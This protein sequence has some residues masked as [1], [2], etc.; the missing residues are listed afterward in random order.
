MQD[1][2]LL[3]WPCPEWFHIPISTEWQDIKQM[4]GSLWLDASLPNTYITN[5]KLQY[6]WYIDIY[7][8][9]EVID[10]TNRNIY[11]CANQYDWSAQYA[12]AF[13]LWNR[14][15]SDPKTA[16]VTNIWK[17]YWCSIRPFK[18][19]PVIPDNTWTVLYDW[20]SIAA[21]AWTFRNQWLWLVSIS[22]DWFN[23][24]TIS[25]TDLS[26]NQWSYYQRW[27]NFW[28]PSY[29]DGDDTVNSADTTW[30]WPWNYYSSWVLIRPW[31][32][33]R[34]A[35]DSPINP[36][37]WWYESFI[38]GQNDIFLWEWPYDYSAM[39]WQCQEWYHI[40]ESSELRDFYNKV[41]TFWLTLEDVWFPT[42][43]FLQDNNWNLNI[44]FAGAE[45]RSCNSER[46]PEW[47]EY[48]EYLA[49]AL[50][51]TW[52][53]YKWKWYWCYIRP[54]R[55]EPIIPDNSWTIIYDGS[56]TASWAWIFHNPSLG[57][58]SY[59]SDWTTWK[60]IA[61]KNLW[62]ENVYVNWDWYSQINCWWFFQ[63]WNCYMFPYTWAVDK[64]STLVAVSWY[65][66]WNYYSSSTFVKA[67]SGWQSRDRASDTGVG[68]EDLWWWKTWRIWNYDH[69]ELY[70]WN[71]ISKSLMRWPCQE[72]WH[73]PSSI[74]RSW[75][76]TIME[77]IFAEDEYYSHINT[78][79]YSQYLHLPISWCLHNWERVFINEQHWF[80]WCSTPDVA[81]R[82]WYTLDMN[83]L[84]WGY[85]I[86]C[87][88][89]AYR[90]RWIHIRPF[91]D[92][93][94]KQI[95]GWAKIEYRWEYAIYYNSTQ[96]LISLTDWTNRYTLSDKNLWAT[97]VYNDWDTISET[98][99][100][101]FFQWW[102]NYMFPFEWTTNTSNATVDATWYWP[103]NYYS[104]STFIREFNYTDWSNPQ[105]DNLRWWA[106]QATPNVAEVYKWTTL[107]RSNYQPTTPT[108]WIYWNPTKWMISISDDW[109]RWMTISDR[110]LWAKRAY[111]SWDEITKDNVWYLFQ[112]WNN[113]PF[114]YT[115]TIT[116]TSTQVDT[117]SY[118]PSSYRNK[119]FVTWCTETNPWATG[120]NS[121]NLRW[122]DSPKLESIKWP[123]S[124]WFHI[125]TY[126][127]RWYLLN[128]LNVRWISNV[129]TFKQYLKI[130]LMG[131]IRKDN[132]SKI[133][134]VWEYWSSTHVDYG[135]HDQS[136]LNLKIE[137]DLSLDRESIA[138]WY[139]IR[140][141]KNEA[142]EPD[143]TWTKLYAWTQSHIHAWIFHNA[144]LWL[145]TISDYTQWRAITISDKNLWAT[146]VYND[147]DTM[148]ETNCGW[149]FQYGNNYMFPFTW[150]T[151]TSSTLVDTTWYWPG[152][153]Y[154]SS[155]FITLNNTRYNDWW[156]TSLNENI[157]WYLDTNYKKAIWPC[158]IWW[159]IPTRLDALNIE[160]MLENIR[161][162]N[163]SFDVRQCLKIPTNQIYIKTDWT[164]SNYS[165]Y[166][167]S[168]LANSVSYQK[169]YSSGTAWNT[170]Q[171]CI[172]IAT[173][174]VWNTTTQYWFPI[175]PFKD[176]PA[177]PND[178][179]RIK[180]A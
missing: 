151:A 156:M 54:F 15:W 117:S 144:T 162:I 65:W 168:L 116:T 176:E 2:S 20:S 46:K 41:S 38:A 167:T 34:W 68:T 133:T 66:P 158:N 118:W 79:Y 110:N 104:S 95:S 90:C 63:R 128:R 86:T 103:W 166:E 71:W 35:R 153:Y 14:S 142:I 73:I 111:N 30:Y 32:T 69:L 121:L 113:Y 70:V 51:R 165:N 75:V 21:W 109:S 137:S 83:N 131:R 123:C 58:I 92:E 161:N 91:K 60:T 88:N 115:K 42:Y 3:R 77:H 52:V 48:S 149:F 31:S 146:V 18:N 130:P 37:L 50:W 67:P 8:L 141:F 107:V 64:S 169:T 154:S 78:R 125:P 17:S 28:F 127:E 160:D 178:T 29:T 170:S 72:W 135:N 120:Y 101:W 163:S 132:G 171:R 40:P 85:N 177:I 143:N 139:S 61:D 43:W 126:T 55:D 140:P 33:G 16:S 136:A 93:P 134:W 138:N 10:R 13:E 26:S 53:W 1:Y 9:E 174:G 87:V 102:N 23:W 82:R 36:N 114:D 25:D 24:I 4:I 157:R 179:S 175:R 44:N 112:W 129:N 172:D 122:W 145:I 45:Y 74:E 108:A 56:S 22:N 62:A 150:P 49:Y 39:R 96:W 11:R 119:K 148:S 6:R 98:N 106:S 19:E 180:L 59:S 80:Y 5:I 12:Y 147:W 47:L 76:T 57:V 94:I 84:S 89:Y 100:W 105:N 81:D 159:H 124:D 164:I 27:N 97:T 173:T 155:T 7:Q 99:C 152:N